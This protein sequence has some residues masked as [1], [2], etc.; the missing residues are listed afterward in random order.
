MIVLIID[1]SIV[2]FYL[3]KKPNLY[4]NSSYNSNK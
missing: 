4:N 3:N 1:L 2:L